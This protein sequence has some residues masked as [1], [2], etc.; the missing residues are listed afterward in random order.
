[1]GRACRA[2]HVPASRPQRRRAIVQR[3]PTPKKGPPQPFSATDGRY[4]SDPDTWRR[5]GRPPREPEARTAR[6]N[7]LITPETKQLLAAKLMARTYQTC[8]T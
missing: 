3:K 4:E 7:F 6:A 2:D 5:L 1:L 8:W